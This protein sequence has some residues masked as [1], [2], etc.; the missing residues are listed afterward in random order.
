MLI[1]ACVYSGGEGTGYVALDLRV[2]RKTVQV[3]AWGM[4]AFLWRTGIR[5]KHVFTI[6]VCSSVWPHLLLLYPACMH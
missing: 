4:P 1:C 2:A 6:G 5:L 3:A